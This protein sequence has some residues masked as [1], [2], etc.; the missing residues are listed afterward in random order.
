MAP[1]KPCAPIRFDRV[2]LPLIVRIFVFA[3]C[4][5]RPTELVQPAKCMFIGI[6]PT[7]PSAIWSCVYFHSN[8]FSGALSLINTTIGPMIMCGMLLICTIFAF[9]LCVWSELKESCRSWIPFENFCASNVL[10]LDRI[11]T[12]PLFLSRSV[13]NVWLCVWECL[14]AFVARQFRSR[15]GDIPV[16]W[17]CSFVWR[18]FF[19]F[20]CGCCVY[21]I[22]SILLCCV[23]TKFS[24]VFHCCFVLLVPFTAAYRTEIA[25][26]F[27]SIVE[28]SDS[29][30]LKS[31]CDL[32][33]EARTVIFL[34]LFLSSHSFSLSR[35]DNNQNT[36]NR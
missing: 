20:V 10:N 5:R 33:W 4:V 16:S 36:R 27:A 13:G 19:F 22:I 8:L 23:H 11:F 25:F 15:A 7:N 26:Q 1:I 9:T 35:F 12:R 17:L 14:F 21:F 29:E 24:R 2:Q 34:F 30:K 6:W 18:T 28:R 3:N 32:W 31:L